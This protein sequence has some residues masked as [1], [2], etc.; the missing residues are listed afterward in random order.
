MQFLGGVGLG[1]FF[2]DLAY[3]LDVHARLGRTWAADQCHRHKAQ[4]APPTLGRISHRA[5]SSQR[6]TCTEL[7]EARALTRSTGA[8]RCGFCTAEPRRARRWPSVVR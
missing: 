2:D 4:V 8:A 6:R 5:W 3:Q 1:R 7:P